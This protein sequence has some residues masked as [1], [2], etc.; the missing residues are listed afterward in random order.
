VGPADRR[1]GADAP[2]RGPRRRPRTDPRAVPGRPGVRARHAGSRTGLGGVERRAARRAASGSARDWVDD[3]S[4]GGPA[5]GPVAGPGRR[6]AAAARYRDRDQQRLDRAA[7]GGQ[8]SPLPAHGRR[9]G[10]D[11]PDA[12]RARAA[13]RGRPEDRA[14]RQPHRNDRCLP[15]RRA[16]A[17]R[18]GVRRSRQPVRPSRPR[19]PPARLRDGGEGLPDRRGRE[20]V[21]RARPWSGAGRPG[22][23]ARGAGRPASGGHARTGDGSGCVIAGATERR[24]RSDGRRRGA[25]PVRLRRADGAG[26]TRRRF[27]CGPTPARLESGDCRGVSCG[28]RSTP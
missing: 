12:R 20:R 9:R 1:R 6:P 10:G 5:A 3:P 15:R 13:P 23:H 4:R 22:G 27:D 19:D 2:A 26:A 24:Y 17:D 8:R 28:L 7:R 11:R 25:L 14:P 16:P 18:G 21:D